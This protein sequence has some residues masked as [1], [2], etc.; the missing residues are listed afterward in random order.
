LSQGAGRGGGTTLVANAHSNQCADITFTAD[1]ALL[2][3][4]ECMNSTGVSGAFLTGSPS[5]K[6]G[7]MRNGATTDRIGMGRGVLV[8]AVAAVVVGRFGVTA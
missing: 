7:S 6:G 3:G 4:S 8:A 5:G 1:A 2:Q